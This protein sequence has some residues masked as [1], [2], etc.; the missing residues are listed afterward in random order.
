M[1][2]VLP[3]FKASVISR[4]VRFCVLTGAVLVAGCGRADK[5]PAAELG[6][7]PEGALAKVGNEWILQSDLRAYQALLNR[8]LAA[9]TALEELIAHT[10]LAQAAVASGVH[11][12]PAVR[13]QIR[14]VLATQLLETAAVALAEPDEALLIELYQQQIG[15]FTESERVAIAVLRRQ[16][17]DG[18]SQLAMAA[19]ASARDHFTAPEQAQLPPASGFGP[20]AANFSDEPDTRFNG[21]LVGWVSRGQSHFLLPPEVIAAAADLEQSGAISSVIMSSHAAWLVRITN[22][23]EKAVRPLAHVRDQLRIEWHQQ[24]QM[25]AANRQRDAARNAF[26]V[27]WVNPPVNDN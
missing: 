14:L 19:M 20:A 21:G 10:Q 13:T 4:F 6:R 9:E 18:G 7:V 17:N 24:R 25:D 1:L 2:L 3:H 16:F 11:D 15:R 8:P 12:L 26:P 23:S 22:R 5:D 27:Q